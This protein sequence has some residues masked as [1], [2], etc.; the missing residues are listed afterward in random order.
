MA[1]MLKRKGKIPSWSRLVAWWLCAHHS[2]H[3]AALSSAKSR[4]YMPP[5]SSRTQ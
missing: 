2:L 5:P 1:A 3:H 4:I